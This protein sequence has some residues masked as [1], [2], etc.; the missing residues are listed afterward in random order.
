MASDTDT[1]EIIPI[2]NAEMRW[3]THALSTFCTVGT[4]TSEED[5]IVGE[6]LKKIFKAIEENPRMA[7]FA[8]AFSMQEVQLLAWSAAAGLCRTMEE[9]MIR[10]RLQERF[11]KA[12]GAT[13]INGI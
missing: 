5:G 6:M 8:M 3:L 13:G 11:E 4:R 12:S 1:A 2:R 10:G 7:E 9:R